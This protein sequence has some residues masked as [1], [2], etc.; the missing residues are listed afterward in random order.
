MNTI[1]FTLR[2]FKNSIIYSL[3]KETG[4]TSLTQYELETQNGLY[5]LCFNEKTGLF[6]YIDNEI[7]HVKNNNYCSQM[8]S[9]SFLNENVKNYLYITYLKKYG[10]DT[11]DH[12]YLQNENYLPY[13]VVYIPYNLK[14]NQ[15][16]LD[17]KM[18][19]KNNKIYLQGNFV[20]AVINMLGYSARYH[21]ENGGY[22]FPLNYR[23][24]LLQIGVKY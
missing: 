4:Y 11:F 7:P 19:F 14:K 23:D 1:F 17:Y 3:L 24:R 21:L 9:M 22:E 16:N 2:H 15:I 13:I 12:Y 8:I 18:V 20:G 6:H 5:E 10:Y